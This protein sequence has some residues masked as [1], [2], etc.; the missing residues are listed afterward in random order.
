[1]EEKLR[2][3]VVD[4]DNINNYIIERLV[5]KT[6]Y[7]IE[8]TSCK[9]GAET[10]EY[11]FENKAISILPNVMIVDI[12]MPV[13]NGWEL[14]DK[15][16]E[17]YPTEFENTHVYMV[18]SSV[19]EHDIIKTKAYNLIKGFIS[20]PLSVIKLNEIFENACNLLIKQEVF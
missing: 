6:D 20:K 16:Q 10:L 3:L 12:N 18:S 13:M 11:L 1:M 15:L 14:L 4:D 7:K 2:L 17:R 9:N 8:F 19:Y 5:A